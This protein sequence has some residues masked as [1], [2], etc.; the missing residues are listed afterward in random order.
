MNTLP[1]T[2]L[3]RPVDDTMMTPKD[4]RF[5]EIVEDK[6]KILHDIRHSKAEPFS[7]QAVE[8]LVAYRVMQHQTHWPRLNFAA[9]GAGM[10]RS[11]SPP[12]GG[13]Q[14]ER[15][16]PTRQ[17]SAESSY[18]SISRLPDRPASAPSV[19]WAA[20]KSGRLPSPKGTKPSS[21]HRRSSE[22]TSTRRDRLA[23]SNGVVVMDD[24]RK[25]RNDAYAQTNESHME[26]SDLQE[27]LRARM[28]L[29]EE[30]EARHAQEFEDE[31]A[32][33]AAEL[34][35]GRQEVEAERVA[36]LEKL[37]ADRLA[38]EAAAQ[39]KLE[40]ER[41]A[42]RAEL[43]KAR[44]EE[45][46]KLEE[47][48]T[49]FK[50]ECEAA[51]DAAFAKLATERGEMEE[52]VRQKTEALTKETAALRQSEETIK[53]D[54]ARLDG[55]LSAARAAHNDLQAQSAAEKAKLTADIEQL[56]SEVAA[57]G[58][59]REAEAK[60]ASE[61][62][63]ANDEKL[64]AALAQADKLR[65]QLTKRVDEAAQLRADLEKA[66]AS[67]ASDAGAA[68]AL[69]AQLD[70]ATA[71]K[72]DV[73]RE[74][75]AAQATA[76][77]L[78]GE[79]EKLRSEMTQKDMLLAQKDQEIEQLRA[80]LARKDQQLAD[81]AIVAEAAAVAAATAPRVSVATT[82][83]AQAIGTCDICNG[84]IVDNKV[85]ALGKNYHQEHFKCTNCGTQLG[86][87]VNFYDAGGV[88]NCETCYKEVYCPKCSTCNQPVVGHCITAMGKKWHTDHFICAHCKKPLGD[89]KFFE[90][91]GLPYCSPDFFTLFAPKCTACGNSI[92]G[93]CVNALGG[94]WHPAHFTC[95]IC[96]PS[97]K[98]LGDQFFEWAGKP[99]CE[100]HFA[101][102]SGK[103]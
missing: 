47:E 57:A 12:R 4:R 74:L 67:N 61:R 20:D 84:P 91:N 18:S 98:G 102:K 16:R 62:E 1:T 2:G 7:P 22:S 50:T 43:D 68:Q 9:N 26:L 81:M 96:G 48:K 73:E 63:K 75:K 40:E 88:P 97:S 99:V 95:V 53:K 38:A 86:N 82:P 25:P 70:A 44:A 23:M 52:Q 31:R 33:I 92:S 77:Q 19:A 28:H 80:Q 85:Q 35:A 69:R 100:R 83:A 27:R 32:R 8:L 41:A 6:E 101:E 39:A 24:D 11:V 14:T 34:E 79:V 45:Q 71:A 46:A 87:G 51:R 5:Y 103:K 37:E 36:M 93:D 15:A 60:A 58:R 59:E 3:V 10:R 56:R 89:E 13:S 94:T 90:K 42:Y 72:G 64:T 54:M 49:A 21:T 29:Q 66:S 17:A 78:R 30:T 55:E 65:T 76:T